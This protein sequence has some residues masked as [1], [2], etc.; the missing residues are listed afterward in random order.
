MIETRKD[1]L[2]GLYY[3]RQMLEKMQIIMKQHIEQ[4]RALRQHL[5]YEGLK[6]HT[7]E[8]HATTIKDKSK[9]AL[10]TVFLSFAALAGL[11][12][13][14]TRKPMY[15]MYYAVPMAFL[16][17][18]KQH[19]KLRIAAVAFLVLFTFDLA[20]AMPLGTAILLL[21]L[22]VLVVGGELIFFRMYN[23]RYVVGKN[24]RADAHNRA[25]MAATDAANERIDAY[26]QPI[27]ARRKQLA[28]QYRQLCEELQRNTG[29]W[30]PPDYYSIEAVEH[31][32]HAV[33][34]HKADNVR[35]M[36]LEYDASQE[37][38]K[39]L[40]YQR[41]QSD[42]LNQLI[43]L[44]NLSLQAQEDENALLRQGNMLQ[45]YGNLINAS[46]AKNIKGIQKDLQ[47]NTQAVRDI[48]KNIKQTTNI[49][50]K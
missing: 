50:Y 48:P 30:F 27:N 45:F 13:W 47:E 46:N 32:I 40:K 29:D 37:R 31:F 42:K 1:L 20:S 14:I 24:K 23:Q 38:A 8:L 21:V 10:I 2:N 36:V 3:I 28:D 18:D 39:S 49:Y 5:Q 33:R 9:L 34:N 7:K 19:R 16:L 26:N 25:V 35:D 44:Q 43:E 17:L 15:F 11:I 4:E 22:A 41:Q 6:A 12:T